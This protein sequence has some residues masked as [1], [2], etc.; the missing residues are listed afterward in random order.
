M[1]NES[2]PP[3][4][5][6]A[7]WTD[8]LQSAA[9]SAGRAG[10]WAIALGWAWLL[11][12][13]PPLAFA[14]DSGG[15]ESSMSAHSATSSAQRGPMSRGP[16]RPSAAKSGKT[17]G[18][19][20]SR[21]EPDRRSPHRARGVTPARTTAS[22]IVPTT[23]AGATT[24]E[25]SST[26][27]GSNYNQLHRDIV[28]RADIYGSP[29]RKP[30][31]LAANYGFEGIE[32]IPGLTSEN[33]INLAIAAGAGVVGQLVGLDPAA[34]FRNIT[35]GSSP[36]G[37][38]SAGFSDTTVTQTFMDA[39]PI[40]FSYPVL[41]STVLPEN[42]RVQLNTGEVVTPFY[43]AQNPNY[44][45]NERQTIVAFGNFGNRL[46]TDDPDAVYPVLF[47]VVASST[48]LKL[49][50]SHGL[51]DGTG[52][53]KTS[54]NP[55]D[56]DSGPTLVGAKLSR[57]SLAGDYPPAG[58]PVSVANHGVEY[59]GTDPK[60]YRLR[61]FT[62]G[63][64]SPDGVSPILPQ[65][66]AK[67]F[68]LTAAGM[69]GQTVTVTQAGV[70]YRVRGGYIEVKGIADMGTGLSADPEYTYSEDFDNQFDI[71]VWASSPLA[72]RAIRDVV[73]PD[74]T[75]GTHNPIYNPG[76]PGTEPVPGYRYTTPS[77]GQTISVQVALHNSKTVSWAEQSLSDY[78]QANDLAVAFR[79]K[80]ATTREWRLTS[81][82]ADASTLV[83]SGQWE[84]VDVP[85]A[86]NAND[87][88][89]AD[90][91]QLHNASRNDTVYT[92][93]PHQIQALENAGYVNEGTA[94]TA[95]GERLRGLDP[96][97]QMVSPRG[98]HAVTASPLERFCWMLHGWRPQGVAFYTVTF[99]NA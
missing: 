41:P 73:I 16:A 89:V 56:P 33:E 59:Y 90:V 57:L 30:Q 36:A 69:C 83:D 17:G 3:L 20:A 76:G 42:F 85:F 22:S 38:Q 79:L 39:M 52:L 15:S 2:A 68:Q 55:Y 61:L 88:Y 82:S 25:T 70:K 27:E 11:A 97:W 28:I 86:T 48:P 67:Y 87:S 71:V 60:L 63:G 6:A 94:F 32:G 14:D 40:E 19:T 37:I 66:F 21:T 46:P 58:F 74:P 44:D 65:D 35:T 62:T 92:A 84:L 4:R 7:W 72:A 93:N 99:P 29:W 51:V 34:P 10:A 43:V 50:T 81:S 9:S 98:Q 18:T 53:S 75:T 12:S 80:N 26:D 78:D 5:F 54:S 45:F 49:I 1:N 77:P 91:V 24:T 8:S 47:E 31:I 23:T 96:V 64:F 95:Y 13:V